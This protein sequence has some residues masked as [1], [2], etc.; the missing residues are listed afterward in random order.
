[1]AFQVKNPT[2]K[3]IIDF[4]KN[5]LGS[6]SLINDAPTDSKKYGRKNGFWVE[7]T[8]GGGGGGGSNIGDNVYTEGDQLIIE[9]SST[10]IEDF[11]KNIAPEFDN[12]VSHPIN[13]L[14]LYE[15][16]LYTL[17]EAHTAPTTWE[18]TSHT[19][20][21]I[22][23]ILNLKAPIANPTFTGTPQI[24]TTPTENS[25]NY[26]IADTAYVDRAATKRE[27]LIITTGD[28]SSLPYSVSGSSSIAAKV[29]DDMVPITMDLSNPA[30][31][32]GTWKI[33]TGAAQFSITG[34][35]AIS[36]TTNA[37]LYFIKTR[38][39]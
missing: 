27:V 21:V 39:S 28:F 33:T 16:Q 12:T 5:Q 32:T 35:N 29:E 8:E 36:G 19:T 38:T 10:Q 3:S 2:L 9:S 13:S 34:T 11:F 23:D 4:L 30:A 31:Q 26:A 25:N 24:S 37:T 7:I 20:A 17:T 15:N 14:V 18:N 22:S 6:M 1:M